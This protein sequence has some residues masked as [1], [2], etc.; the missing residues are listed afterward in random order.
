LVAL[1]LN[2][3][4]EQFRG[5]AKASLE[6]VPLDSAAEELAKDATALLQVADDLYMHRQYRWMPPGL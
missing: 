2:R 1:S 5:D 4:V 6:R 3:V